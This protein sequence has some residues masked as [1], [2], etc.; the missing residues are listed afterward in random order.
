MPEEREPWEVFFES[1]AE[2]TRHVPR[3]APIPSVPS[4]R[5]PGFGALDTARTR[6]EVYAR[7]VLRWSRPEARLAAGHMAL[8]LLEWTRM[9]GEDRSALRARLRSAQERGRA[10][11]V[12]GL[13]AVDRMEETLAT[14]L[15]LA[16]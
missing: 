16:F 3:V 8:I 14:Q 5:S 12:L 4:E 1:W 15:Q 10:E 7:N 9:D 2:R 11:A 6:S 13:A